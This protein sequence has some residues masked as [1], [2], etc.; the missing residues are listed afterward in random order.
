VTGTGDQGSGG[1]GR[2]SKLIWP[3]RRS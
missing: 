3:N 2:R 1:V